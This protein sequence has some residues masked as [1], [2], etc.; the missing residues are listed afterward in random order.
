MIILTGASGGIGQELIGHL[1]GIDNV[2]GLF[3]KDPIHPLPGDSRITYEKLDLLD[4]EKIEAFAGVNKNRLSQITLV[5]GASITIDELAMKYKEDAWDRVMGVNLKGNFLLTQALLPKMLEEKWGRIISL[6]SIRG[7]RGAKGAIA[8]STS[9]SALLGMSKTLAMEYGRFNITSNILSLGYFQSGLMEKVS[10][11]LQEQMK[12]EIPSGKFGDVI[13][14][15]HAI[16][17]LIKSEYSN[18]TVI[19]ID[20]GI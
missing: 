5:H 3:N 4:R 17:F 6:S 7:M 9:K 13:N 12:K 19:N 15:A 8:Y 14:I 16:E 18:G 1:S 20:G 10:T 2:I 11:E